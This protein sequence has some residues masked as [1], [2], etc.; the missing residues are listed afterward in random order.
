[1]QIS[2]NASRLFS[3]L[4]L[5]VLSFPDGAVHA[6]RLR[7]PYSFLTLSG[8]RFTALGGVNVSLADTDPNSFLAN[9][10]LAGDTLTG[11]A[12]ASHQF[13]FGE[14][15]VSTFSFL[16]SLGK[17]GTVA[18]GVQH[19]N[20][21]TLAG[22]D[23]S[24]VETGEFRASETALVVSKTRQV[25]F[26]RLGVSIKGAFSSFEAFRSSALIADVGGVFMHPRRNL[27]VGLVIRNLGVI[28]SD[29]SPW[30]DSVL[31]FDVQA[32]VTFKPEHM[33]FRFSF[34][35]HRI[36]DS[37]AVSFTDGQAGTPSG[38]ARFSRHFNFA[39]ELL[40]HRNVNL[41][42]GFNSARH[43][44]LRLE[45]GGGGSGVTLGFS[46]RIKSVEFVFSNSTY[47]AGS[48]SVSFTLSTDVRRIIRK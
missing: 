8:G 31:P 9:P 41:L 4:L 2:G 45:D 19:L 34:T 44:E 33:P 17:F 18:F 15:G 6:Q 25:R 7:S 3:L 28:L 38:F 12:S 1:M 42:F 16:P 24:G 37:P 30:S 32:G 39:T 26:V 36:V 43:Q 40:L 11:F 46:A 35:A 14:Y 22:Y 47:V 23:A 13:F 48:N 27:Q 10:S 21:G 5:M 20:Y 29:Y